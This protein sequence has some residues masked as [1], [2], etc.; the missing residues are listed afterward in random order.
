LI[1]WFDILYPF[2]QPK[3]ALEAGYTIVSIPDGLVYLVPFAGYYYD[4][5]NC[6]YLYEHWEPRIVGNYVV[7]DDKL[8]QLAGGKFALWNDALGRKV[9]VEGK[10]PYTETDNW[11]RI[12]PALQTLGQKFW[13]GARPDQPWAH[14][15]SLADSKGEPQG[16]KFSRIFRFNPKPVS[17]KPMKAAK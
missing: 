9:K 15:A 8:D 10:P 13:T 11:D 6:R 16:V 3:E 4:Y 2:Y 5:L 1:E 17:S 7:P 12:Y 14:F